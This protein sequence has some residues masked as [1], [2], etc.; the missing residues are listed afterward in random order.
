M[1]TIKDRESVTADPVVI[2]DSRGFVTHV[3]EAFERAFGWSG[4][5]IIGHLLSEIMPDKFRDA[6]QLGLSRFLTT[7]EASILN[8]PLELEVLTKDGQSLPAEHFIVAEEV[9]S[10]WIFAAI[11]KPR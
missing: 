9:N 1:P 8:Q 5:D 4:E 3:N 2:A 11:I 7:R 6:H 10:A